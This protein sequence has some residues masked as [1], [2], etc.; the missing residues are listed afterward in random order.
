MRAAI[1]KLAFLEELQMSF[2]SDRQNVYIVDCVGQL[3]A[4]TKCRNVQRCSHELLY[5]ECPKNC[6]DFNSDF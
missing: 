3:C 5:C 6:F 4:C 1:H 2:T